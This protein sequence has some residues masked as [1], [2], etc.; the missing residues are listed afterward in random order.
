M[1]ARGSTLLATWSSLGLTLLTAGAAGAQVL[2]PNLRGG[3][4]LPPDQ[5]EAKKTTA[6]QKGVRWLLD[7]QAA[8]GSWTYPN[9]PVKHEHYPMAQGVT[10]LSALTLLKCGVDPKEQAIAKAFDFMEQAEMRYTYAVACVLLAC[11]A[12]ATWSP[13]PPPGTPNDEGTRVRNDGRKKAKPSPQDMSLAKKALAFLLE[14][15]APKG[16]WRYPGPGDEEDLSNTQ[17]VMLALGAAERLGLKVPREVWEKAAARLV[18]VQ[19]ADGPDME[20]F[21]FPG[22]DM[23]WKDLKKIADEFEKELR[24]LDKRFDGKAAETKDEQGLTRA[25]HM[26]TMTRAAAQ[27]VL[28]GTRTR[29]G[30]GSETRGV[31]ARGWCYIPADQPRMNSNDASV[32]GSMTTSGL[33]GL[34]S[35]KAA[36]EG[37]PRYERELKPLMTRALR[38]GAAWLVKNYAIDHNPGHSL[39][40]FYFLY[41]LERVGMLG[42]LDRFGTHDWYQEGAQLLV[43]RQA[44]DGQWLALQG[45][46]GAVPDTCFAMLFLARGTTP[47]VA[48]PTRVRTGD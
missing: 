16:L 18:E 45:T 41:G 1:R 26:Q 12:R 37:S 29:G 40:H 20:P 3:P 9:E 31:K 11:E 30:P 8:D 36:L 25:D 5:L 23:A 39:H 21:P 17:Y 33:V 10:A 4:K 34:L 19:E 28:E 47:V 48:V 2:P 13:P 35:A 38:D 43:A 7:H 32:T 14:H 46:A 6:L 27:K 22:A 44:P 15:Q 42:L 24:K